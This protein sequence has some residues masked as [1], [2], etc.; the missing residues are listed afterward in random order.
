MI[1]YLDSSIL[2]RIALEQRD[3]LAE[4]NTLT[5]GI[6]SDLLPV[7]CHRSLDRLWQQG[8]I[9]EQAL[10][11]KS[12]RIRSFMTRLELRSLE[13]E[14]LQTASQPFPTPLG[15]LDALHL[16]TAM[17]FRARQPNE[18]AFVFATHDL[19]LARAARAMRFDV[20]GA[21]A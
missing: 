20:I 2:L 5:K 11:T 9:S 16:A 14:I 15:T 10:A 8:R 21:P 1:A 4:W 6:S 7:E 17:A 3:P 13:P 12:A 18:R 19:E